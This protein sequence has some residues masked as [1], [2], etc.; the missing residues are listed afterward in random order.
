M[1]RVLESLVQKKPIAKLSG[2]IWIGSA[3][4][5]TPLDFHLTLAQC[6]YHIDMLL[7][8]FLDN[9]TIILQ[10]LC[11]RSART[12]R[13]TENGA[14]GTCNYAR[15]QLISLIFMVE[16]TTAILDTAA[17]DILTIISLAPKEHWMVKI[18]TGVVQKGLLVAA[19]KIGLWLWYDQN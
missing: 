9:S 12:Q 3:T 1:K 19:I 2:V 6:A 16:W 7:H 4:G 8:I 10:A 11:R 14:F 5:F 15:H 17:D 18:A 13:Q